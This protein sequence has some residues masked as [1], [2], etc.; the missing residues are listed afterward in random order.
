MNLNTPDKKKK[1]QK[2]KK[3]SKEKIFVLPQPKL[4]LILV[5]NIAVISGLVVYFEISLRRERFLVD[6]ALE[7]SKQ[8]MGVESIASPL[9]PLILEELK[10]SGKEHYFL[11]KVELVNN[12]YTPLVHLCL[13]E[14]GLPKYPQYLYETWSLV[15]YPSK[16]IPQISLV[17]YVLL[18]Q[19]D[20][21][22]KLDSQCF[23][24]EITTEKDWQEVQKK[25]GFTKDQFTK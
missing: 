18:P 19:D 9:S 15:N 5:L 6:K 4:L 17:R 2:T 3:R 7:I 14:N 8:Q 12:Y 25:Y 11:S 24:K 23:L 22:F 13:F 10:K 16:G 21:S 1:E 20:A